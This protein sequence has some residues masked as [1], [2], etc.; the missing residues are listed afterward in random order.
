[1]FR[2]LVAAL[3]MSVVMTAQGQF[4]QLLPKTESSALPK[5]ETPAQLRERLQGWLK[6]AREEFSR[7]DEPS[8]ESRLPEGVGPTEFSER[9]RDVQQ[10]IISVERQLKSQ[11][12]VAEAAE[13]AKK[14]A[15]Q[16]ESWK[17]FVEGPP[18]SVLW[19]D[20]LRNQRDVANERYSTSASTLKLFENR[21]N[22]SSAEAK[23]AD[24]AYRLASGVSARSPGVADAAWRMEAAR[25]R[26][27]SITARI[28]LFNQLI[29]QQRELLS[30]AGSRL[31][32]VEK[33][34]AQI[35][36]R[37]NLSE[38]DLAQVR[39][40]ATTR[41]AAL[42][43]EG[44]EIRKRYNA[45]L[46]NRRKL[47]SQISEEKPDALLTAR[48][49][50]STT[51]VDSLQFS[52]DTLNALEQLES[53]VPDAYQSRRVLMTVTEVNARE[54]ALKSLRTMRDQS[55]AWGIFA[56][57]EI[58][59][60]GSE[61]RSQEA[62]ALSMPQN[63]PKVPLVNDQCADLRDKL[64]VIQRLARTVDLQQRQ[65]NAWLGDFD[66]I[67]A[68]RSVGQ[69]VSDGWDS[70]RLGVKKLW[71]VGVWDYD[72]ERIDAN[73]QKVLKQEA[74]PLGQLIIAILLFV[75]GYVVASKI[76]RR[77][78]RVVVSKG[79]IGE[80]QCTTLRRWVMALIGFLLGVATLKILNIPLTVFAFLGGALVIGVGFGTQTLIKNFISGI[81][82]L[83]ERNIRVGDI[84]DIGGVV[85]TVA[86]INTRSSVLRSGDGIETLIPNS[87]FLES[88][89][90]N[91]THSNRHIRRSVRV[92]VDHQSPIQKVAE[93]LVDCADRHGLVLKDPAPEALFED[94]GDNALI[95]SLNFWIE[96]DSRTN[97]SVVASDLR[98]MIGKSFADAGIAIAAPSRDMKLVTESPLKVEWAGNNAGKPEESDAGTVVRN[99]D[100]N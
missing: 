75:I 77:V 84:L 32:F 88:R 51:R 86:E 78:H 68:Q 76:T 100:S 2:S 11:T 61:L 38:D 97:S 81:I 3:L 87:L 29:N 22:E 67:L 20:D 98:Y 19:I 31:A 14:A 43:K 85:G 60:A 73:G 9:R 23:A 24:E 57:N 40:S 12:S 45:A 63:D 7:L 6:E 71:D 93:I 46:S 30:E 79:H 48:I 10:T 99:E 70:F 25:L 4:S 91:W 50:A 89:V 90:T 56:A 35:E 21:M 47:E 95:F 37:A 18:Y 72:V 59:V 69:R 27:R 92:G 28:G 44:E 5:E 62:R 15:A 34:L 82:V 58:S 80:A 1:M 65:L 26:C 13:S 64:D 39:K 41:Q 74:L 8:A 17:G 33:Q 16:L 83:F 94:F 53:Q 42:A 49:E 66:Q 55:K 36:S 96:L 54:G 52:L